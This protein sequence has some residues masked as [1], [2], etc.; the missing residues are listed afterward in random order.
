MHRE[1]VTFAF[2]APRPTDWKSTLC[3][4]PIADQWAKAWCISD[5]TVSCLVDKQDANTKELIGRTP[6]HRYA[7][8]T[9]TVLIEGWAEKH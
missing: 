1:R 5:F 6:G 9:V 7:D 4:L 3:L 8:K 2:P